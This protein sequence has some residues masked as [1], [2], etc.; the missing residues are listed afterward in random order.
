MLQQR[1]GGAYAAVVGGVNIDIGGQSFQPLILS[2][3]NPGRVRT[4][5]GGVGRNIAHNLR[6]L[7]LPVRLIAAFGE[8]LYAD[9]IRR[10]CREIGIDTEDAVT[11]PGEATSTYLYLA[12]HTGEMHLAVSDMEICRFLTPDALE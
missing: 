10:S 1:E 4:S 12:D 9:V 8:D 11:V 6:L 3:S 5:P 7:G 2:D